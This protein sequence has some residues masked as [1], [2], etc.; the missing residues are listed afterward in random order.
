M[1][2]A[3][4]Q[5]HLTKQELVHRL[6]GTNGCKISI[7]RL[8]RHESDLDEFKNLLL[9]LMNFKQCWHL[10]D[11]DVRGGGEVILYNA[12]DYDSLLGQVWEDDE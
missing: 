9:V 6:S 7:G 11:T 3:F 12:A 10:L 2:T 8:I 5:T 1:L 4:I